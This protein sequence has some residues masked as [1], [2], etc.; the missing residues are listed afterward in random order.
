[1]R[2]LIKPEDV[3]EIDPLLATELVADFGV[4]SQWHEGKKQRPS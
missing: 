4:Q 1:M 2:K 3:S